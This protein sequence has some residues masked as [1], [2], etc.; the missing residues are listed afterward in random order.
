MSINNNVVVLMKAGDCGHC[1]IFMNVWPQICAAMK[2][3]E[4]SLQ[5]VL[6]PLPTMRSPIPPNFPSC[7]KDTCPWFPFIMMIDG[8]EWQEAMNKKRQSFNK[9][10]FFNATKEGSEFKPSD[11]FPRTEEGFS[12]WA[13]NLIKNGGLKDMDEVKTTIE[14]IPEGLVPKKSSDILKQFNNGKN[15]KIYG[16]FSNCDGDEDNVCS[17]V[18][19][20]KTKRNS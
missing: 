12:N 2:R 7:L 13:K 19:N 4:S 18:I 6:V 5:F 17:L 8:K 14:S 3:V 11:D 20:I 1:K 15:G 9:M 16:D 10:A